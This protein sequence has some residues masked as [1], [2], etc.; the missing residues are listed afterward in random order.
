[1]TTMYSYMVPVSQPTQHKG[2]AKVI[3][4]V[5]ASIAIPF[6][7]PA[8]ATAIGVSAGIATTVASAAIG[9]GISAVVQKVTT[10]KI[11]P[12]GVVSGALL[13]TGGA[14]AA[15][16]GFT[17]AFASAP[18]SLAG[19]P[20]QLLGA[21]GNLP[22][23]G[24]AGG[25]PQFANVGAGLNFG[26]AG[27][28]AAS[29]TAFAPQG[30]T[31]LG[32]GT[33]G[34]GVATPPTALLDGGLGGQS[35]LTP[36]VT[37][38]PALLSVG[39]QPVANSAVNTTGQPAGIN[40]GKGTTSGAGVQVD[41]NGNVIPA[42]ERSIAQRFGDQLVQ[43]GPQFVGRAATDLLTAGLEDTSTVDDP[44]RLQSP[45]ERQL[46]A[47]ETD[48]VA[49]AGQQDE[50]IRRRQLSEADKFRREAEATFDP[51][52]AGNLAL[53]ANAQQFD[54]IRQE[55]INRGSDNKAAT[56]A[57]SRRLAIAQ[58]TAGAG[59]FTQAFDLA[60]RQRNNARSAGI[61]LLPESSASIQ[62]KRIAELRGD[63]TELRNEAEVDLQRDNK[64]NAELFGTLLS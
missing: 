45:Q 36:G 64:R 1:M 18:A 28:S 38:G 31:T 24:A 13:G 55:T 15:Q 59:K 37:D 2:G 32:A 43:R 14:I 21:A 42:G 23:T 48:L 54:R 39:G 17:N 62:A 44:S 30:A 25:G 4:G 7:A 46:T 12:L 26:G 61:R 56:D 60:Q 52:N 53:G 47:Q 19:T 3:I 10:G 40:F 9:A 58:S 51:T 63:Q 50:E 41:A 35:L 49:K 8:I 20:T 33:A 29:S 34:A 16:G 27:S 11:T 22:V 57:A 5:V 6:A